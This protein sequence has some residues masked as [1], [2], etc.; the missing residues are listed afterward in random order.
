MSKFV[1][2]NV[3]YERHASFVPILVRTELAF[4]GP[5]YI[6]SLQG[7]DYRYWSLVYVSVC[8]SDLT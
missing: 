2:C 1:C 6:I 3:I 5:Y 8:V 7:V 4:F